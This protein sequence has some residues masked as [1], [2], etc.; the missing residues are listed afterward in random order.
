MTTFGI[1]KLVIRGNGYDLFHSSI[2]L[3]DQLKTKLRH[4]AET[5]EPYA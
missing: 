5:G 3:P 1:G 2:T 4:A